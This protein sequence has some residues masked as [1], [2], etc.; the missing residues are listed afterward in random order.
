M[1]VRHISWAA[2]HHHI[3]SAAVFAA[4]LPPRRAASVAIDHLP[5]TDAALDILRRH[6][7]Q[8]RPVDLLLAPA[9]CLNKTISLPRAARHA[10]ARA[11]DMEL[12]QQMPARAAGLIWRSEPAERTGNAQP[13]RVHIFKKQKL[14]ELLQC[15]GGA[16]AEVRSV[17]I[18]TDAPVAP[19]FRRRTRADRITRIWHGLASGL[20]V[21]AL[22]GV[23]AIQVRA[24]ATLTARTAALQVEIAG[25]L[26]RAAA[27]KARVIARDASLSGLLT[28]V[29]RF[30][31]D[32]RRFPVLADLT[33]GLDDGVWISS[34]TLDGDVLRMAGFSR[35]DLSDTVRKVQAAPWAAEV[36]IDGPVVVDPVRQENRFQLR[37]TLRPIEGPL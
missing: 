10:V 29:Q 37:V 11:I 1:Q 7:A 33:D 24:T 21:L 25:L 2:L 16:G 32:Y 14:T 30:N 4:G 8:R 15:A 27:E 31:S 26:D 3:G 34:L 28:D 22:G 35:A 9:L 6:A 13:Y 20:A 19:L 5:L 17:A 12:R 18:A 36:A 23:L